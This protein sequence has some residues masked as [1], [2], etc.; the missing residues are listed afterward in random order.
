MSIF[1]VL[2]EVDNAKL[3]SLI[4]EKYPEDYYQLSPRQWLISSDETVI[5][6]TEDLLIIDEENGPGPALVFTISNYYGMANPAIW[7]W[8]K[9]KREKSDE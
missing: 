8:L 9:A 1:V 2:S 6:L 5:K 3:E 7:E 4:K